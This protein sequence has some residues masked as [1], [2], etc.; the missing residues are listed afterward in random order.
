MSILVE[1]FCSVLPIINI[2]FTGCLLSH[3]CCYKLSSQSILLL[4][5]VFPVKFGIIQ[6]VFSILHTCQVMQ[7]HF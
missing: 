6:V 2:V 5:V 1:F 3:V 7:Y 4:Q